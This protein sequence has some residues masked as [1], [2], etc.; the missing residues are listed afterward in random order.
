MNHPIFLHHYPGSPFAEKVRLML[1][2]K[3]LAWQSVFQ[4]MVMP[5]PE[6]TDLTGGYRRIPVLQIGNQVICDTALMADVLEHIAPH[7]S[8]YSA[9]SKGVIRTLSQWAD[10][11]MFQ[12]AMAFNFQPVGAQAV[13]AGAAPEALQAFAADRKAMRNGADRMPPA[14][15]ASTYKSYLRRLSSMLEGQPFLLGDQVSMADF[16]AYHSVWHTIN[17][18]KLGEVLVATPLVQAWAARMAGIGHGKF[19]K[20]SKEAAMAACATPIDA[21]DLFGAS[22]VFQD[23]HGI[24]LGQVVTVRAESF[25]PEVTTGTLAAATRTRYTLA[26]TTNAGHAVHVHFP[27]VGYILKAQE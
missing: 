23:D 24:A 3:Q 11:P 9:S 26:R 8:W 4:P 25:G 1:G 14:D 7:P 12:A 20:S 27:R 18:A 5:K 22:D 15:A 21:A 13:F 6:L 2:F 10:G 16:S 19:D 17:A